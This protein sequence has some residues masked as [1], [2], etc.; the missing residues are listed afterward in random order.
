VLGQGALLLDPEDVE[1]L[2]RETLALLGDPERADALA[3][4][5]RARAA[6]LTWQACAAQTW[7]AY[8][9]ALSD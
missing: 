3:Q 9:R 8:A 6:Q 7:E 5:G 2:A 1:A 4:R